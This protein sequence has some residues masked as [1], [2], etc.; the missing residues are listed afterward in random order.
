MKKRMKQLMTLGLT[1]ILVFTGCT[2]K[3]EEPVIEETPEVVIEEVTEPEEVVEET[4]EEIVPLSIRTETKQKTYYFEDG[5]DAYLYLQYCDVSVEGDEYQKLKRS[6]ENWSMERSE[7]LRSLYASF[8]ESAAEEVE[9]NENFY[10]YSL[11]QTVT[12]ARADDRVLSL[13]DDTYQYVGGEH[14]MFYREGINFDSQ[15]GKRVALS[16]ILSN[17]DNFIEEAKERIIYELREDYGEELFDDYVTVIE[18]LWKDGSEP[19]WYLDAS[20][21]VIVLQEYSV[22]PYAIGSPEIHLPYTE[23][24]PYIKEAYLPGEETGVAAFSA[25]QEVFLSIPGQAEEISMMLMS[26]QQEEVMYNSLWFGQTELELGD[27]LVLENAYI[28]RTE[29][30]IYCML[31][32]DEASDD[33][34]TYIYRLTGGAIEKVDELA[35]AID[36]GNINPQEVR[37]KTWVYMLGTY[38]G[39][40]NYHFDENGEFISEDTEY[41]LPKNEYVLT[42]TVDLPCMA[43]NDEGELS[44]WKLPAGSHIILTAADDNSYV[45]FSIQETGQEGILNVQRSEEEYYHITIGGMDGETL[46]ENDCFEVLPYA[47]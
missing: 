13:L 29:T 27:Y 3:V 28:V 33:Y 38:E 46:D 17:Y 8:E 31:V 9:E 20:G 15:T 36:A 16:D 35:A 47:G 30:D 19:Q 12:T 14:G 2:G 41:Q 5:E 6:V 10:G 21:I 11:Y 45:R 42:T 37:M 39:V 4:V 43:E 7:G 34:V 24:K 32:V 26:E 1:G 22:G 23:F 18:E 25:N 40:K 44:E